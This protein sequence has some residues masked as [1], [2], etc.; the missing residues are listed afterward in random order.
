LPTNGARV[1]SETFY[2]QRELIEK[3]EKWTVGQK[4]TN[5]AKNII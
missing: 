4:E 3:L 2:K 5:T 1:K